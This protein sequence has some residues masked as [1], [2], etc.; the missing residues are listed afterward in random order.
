MQSFRTKV[1]LRTAALLLVASALAPAAAAASASGELALHRMS[2]LPSD[3]FDAGHGLPDAKVN[4]VAVQSNGLTWLGTMRG[5]ARQSGTRMQP[6]H[7][8]DGALDDAIVDL[9]A[10]RGG[11][12]LV[13]TERHGVWRLRNGAWTSLGAPLGASGLRK[14]RMLDDGRRQRVFALGAG[15]A[16]LVGDHWQALPLPAALAP[17]HLFDIAIEPAGGAR[18]PALWLASYGAGL[19]RCRAAP[20][21]EA[22]AIPGPGPRTDEVR[23]LQLQALPGDRHALWV[24][25][26]GGGLARLLDGKWTRWHAGNSDLP[27]DFVSALHLVP[28]PAGDTEL[29]V[30]T[31]SGLAILR[32]DGSWMPPDPR[33]PMLRERIHAIATA[34]T[35][36]GTPLVWVGTDNGAARTPLEG[37]WHL[38]STL[39]NKAN[40]VWALR[41]ERA[42][43]GHERLWLGSDGEGIARYERGHWRRFGLAEGL[44]N[45]SVRSI[46]RVPDGSAEGAL[47]AGVW[48]G[49]VAQLRGERFAVLPTPW[50]KDGEEVVRILLAERD[51]V[52]VSTRYQGLAHWD[53]RQW[54]QPPPGPDVPTFAL[55]ALRVGGDLWFSTWDQGLARLRDGQW[56]LFRGDIGLPDDR[57]FNLSL[58]PDDT[59]KPVL[60]VGS[61]RH[62]VLRIDLSDAD[63]PRL[64]DQPPLPAQ[65]VPTVYG[66]V[67]DGRGDLLVCSDYG[68]ARWQRA[69][70][71]Y[72]STVYHR[73][74]GLPHDECNSSAMQADDAGRVWI[75][76]IGGAAVYAPLV[77]ARD[78]P[79]P[80]L[81]TAVRIGDAP[82]AQAQG[83]V[84]LP[85]ADAPLELQYDLLTGES[86]D[87]NRYRVTLAGA[88]SADQA[89]SADNSRRYPHL[90]VGTHRLR[91]E[92]MDSHGVPAQPIELVLEVP[93]AWWQSPAARA[94]SVIAA[95]ALCWC[96]LRLRL[97]SL[98]RREV[99][100]RGMVQTRTA[101]LE[102]SESELRRAND[103]L[104]R[105]SYTDALTGLGNRRQLFETLDSLCRACA[106]DKRPLAVL[107]VDLDHF[108]A[109]NDSLGHL[110]GDACLQEV[111]Q[112]I[113]S[114][115]PAGASAMRYGGEEFC[116]LLPDAD[117]TTA[118]A[119]AERL[120][121]HVAGMHP[122]CCAGLRPQLTISIGAVARVPDAACNADAL[123][124]LADR[125]LYRAKE[126]GRNRVAAAEDQNAPSIP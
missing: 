38:V 61:G 33:V 91:I 82:A 42:A 1:A 2:W 88:H 53:G 102:E 72:R 74:D 65:P 97:R 93:R 73:R 11:D 103:E 110:S 18:P 123:L 30:G 17:Y 12:L 118:V 99:Q 44:P 108:K 71:G 24:G 31:R 125:A 98:I 117:I 21:C 70:A 46:A 120:R 36:Q 60:W 52:W 79:A 14:L 58:L 40:G 122:A 124:L 67:R 84:R 80:L 101:Q 54:R 112:A 83:V 107:M 50:R 37:A 20:A 48:G 90:P 13:S 121:Q 32:D 95:L 86:E 5:L 77:P 78:R 4:A 22:V 45:L 35:S 10:T 9:A 63:R 3:T 55:A 8:P 59:G 29:W 68:V 25:L 43:D 113:Q 39:G 75:G 104:R 92:A 6:Q 57:L 15:V 47:W 89:W 16:E 28:T 49:D 111:A 51:N 62:G 34:S 85:S 96:L 116:L 109:L 41:V 19:F 7:G 69:G 115:L 87:G 106:L 23:L 27:S 94:L 76:T 126:D 119:V 114:G 64:V 56:R 26:Q 105:L 100:L 66:A 81:L